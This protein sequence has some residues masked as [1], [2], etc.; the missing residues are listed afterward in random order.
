MLRGLPNDLNL[1]LS[2]RVSMALVYLL[3]GTAA[4]GAVLMGS[5]LLAP[6][7]A[8]LFLVLVRY[9]VEGVPNLK[10]KSVLGTLALGV[11]IMAMAA[12]GGQFLLVPPV[13]FAY[14]LVFLKHRYS[15]GPR[16]KRVFGV[17]CGTYLVAT[18]AFVV[19]FLPRSPL[20]WALFA[21]LSAVIWLNSS[22]Y[23][24]LASKRGKLF[25]LAAI[26]FHILFHFYNGISFAIGLARYSWG[27]WFQSEERPRLYP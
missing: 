6:L 8:L 21:M 14:L 1:Q 16:Y 22:F 24:F 4:L 7:L 18:M 15:R 3:I 26:P 20:V 12:A 2:H 23:L 9:E 27:V 10:F 5:A 25:A 19:A 11:T 13:M 17:I